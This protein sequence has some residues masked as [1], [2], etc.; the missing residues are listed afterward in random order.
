VHRVLYRLPD[1]LPY[2]RENTKPLGEFAELAA[3]GVPAVLP[4]WAFDGNLTVTASLQGLAELE[5]RRALLLRPDVHV[6][7]HGDLVPKPPIT[8][9]DGGRVVVSSGESLASASGA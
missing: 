2:L 3:H 5:H 7:R 1:Q 8:R 9:D 4:G 6:D